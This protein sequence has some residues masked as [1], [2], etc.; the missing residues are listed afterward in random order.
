MRKIMYE[1]IDSVEDNNYTV[2]IDLPYYSDTDDWKDDSSISTYKLSVQAQSVA[3]A[4]KA[5][6]KFINARKKSKNGIAWQTA[7]ISAIK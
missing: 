1:D 4:E 7:K 3:D 2:I 6:Q 5:A